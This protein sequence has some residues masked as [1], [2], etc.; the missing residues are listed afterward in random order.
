MIS[1]GSR[2]LETKFL[3]LNFDLPLYIMINIGLLAGRV[4]DEFGVHLEFGEVQV[5]VEVFDGRFVVLGSQPLAD[6]ECKII[7]FGTI[8]LRVETVRDG[9]LAERR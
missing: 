4:P 6:V 2:I 9:L 1:C 3:F 5:L 8:N 7:R